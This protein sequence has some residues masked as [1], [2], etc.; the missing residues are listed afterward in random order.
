MGA[1]LLAGALS[2]DSGCTL[3]PLHHN[4]AVFAISGLP[5]SHEVLVD[6]GATVRDVCFEGVGWL[7]GAAAGDGAATVTWLDRRA[8]SEGLDDWVADDVGLVEEA[9][10][11]VLARHARPAVVVHA[12]G[13]LRK[14]MTT[15]TPRLI[16]MEGGGGSGAATKMSIRTVHEVLATALVVKAS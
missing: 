12:R 10:V 4:L 8:N 5:C 2:A 6:G 13:S 1:Y 14:A 11:V 3:S 9:G 15:T 7:L 16:E